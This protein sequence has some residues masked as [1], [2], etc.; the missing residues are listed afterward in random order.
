MTAW[1]SSQAPRAATAGVGAMLAGHTHGGQ[2][3]PAHL[4]V[5]MANQGRVSGLFDV[6][7]GRRPGQAHRAFADDFREMALYV[8]EGAV[9]WGPR[10]RLWSRTELTL[11]RLVQRGEGAATEDGGHSMRHTRPP[12]STSPPPPTPPRGAV[13][14]PPDARWGAAFMG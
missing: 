14:A 10:L 3:W 12:H 1:P 8:G 7:S 9:G 11:V 6:G 5:Y 4:G 2:L 13:P